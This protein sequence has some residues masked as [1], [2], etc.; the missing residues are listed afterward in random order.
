MR[1]E[2]K[3]KVSKDETLHL[4]FAA[5]QT[6]TNGLQKLTGGGDQIILPQNWSINS[7]VEE[8]VDKTTGNTYTIEQFKNAFPY[9]INK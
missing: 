2:A 8:V 1:F 7:W 6:S 9:I 3:I 4:G 5:E